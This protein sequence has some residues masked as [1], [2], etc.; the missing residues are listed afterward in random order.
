MDEAV[1]GN[2]S[3]S[4]GNSLTSGPKSELE[5]NCKAS[6]ETSTSA[7]NFFLEIFMSVIL[8]HPT[9]GARL[10]RVLI[11][12]GRFSSDFGLTNILSETKAVVVFLRY[13][14]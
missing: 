4:M 12:T 5:R 13:L 3:A 6:A 1:P 8:D 7:M 10:Q 11:V 14:L 9:S 2:H